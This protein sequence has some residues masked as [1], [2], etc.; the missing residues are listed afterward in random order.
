MNQT[1][2]PA[3]N[4]PTEP[5]HPPTTPLAPGAI[6]RWRGRPH[7]QPTYARQRTRRQRQAF[8]DLHPGEHVYFVRRQHP[9]FLVLPIWPAAL[10]ALALALLQL[11]ASGNVRLAALFFLLRVLA[12][13]VLIID[14]L[15]WLT[16][17][18][19]AW[20][21]SIYILTDQ[22]LVDQRGFF[23]PIRKEAPLD[24]IQQVQIDRNNV[25]EYLFGF[26]NVLIVTAGT[27]GDL[28]FNRISSPNELADQIRVAEQMYR[29][30]RRAEAPIEPHHPVVKRVLD[31]V[32][33]PIPT[34][35][36]PGVPHRT[37]GGFL[38][39]PAMIRFFDDEVVVDYIYRHPW[40]LIR[41]ELIPAAIV[42]AG[43]VAVVPLVATGSAF[44]PLGLLAVLF[45]AVYGA[46]VYLNYADDV[47]I[48]TTSR[49]V[50]IDRFVFIF[51]EGRKQ[52][53]YS[54]IQD[55]RVTVTS[56]VGRTL[57]YGNILVETA[58]RL[59]NIEMTDIPAPFAVQD[60]IAALINAAK[61]REALA[62]ANRQRQEDRRLIAATMNQVLVQV[63]S[64]DRQFL[65]EAAERLRQV[66]LRYTIEAERRVPGVPPGVV[67]AQIPSPGATAVVDSEVFLTLSGR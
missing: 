4:A 34:P 43:V 55:V 36:P 9:I 45:G 17:D 15:K 3:N 58:G 59:P 39:R 2:P 21:T 44:W 11:P 56:L 27:H 52:A 28:S 18:L 51:F 12:W 14:T 33:A 7:H 66:G 8:S 31:E 30:G 48:L 24:R 57:N 29:R 32:A 46:L 65:L 5:L 60:K 53:D 49:V 23:F 62:A 67:V 37:Y 63:P 41:R 20:L 19:I 64:V 42:I 25:F 10:A 38:R 35:R 22:R 40:V 26:G 50:D 54:R 1:P 61:E 16:V 6:P 13:A 47:F